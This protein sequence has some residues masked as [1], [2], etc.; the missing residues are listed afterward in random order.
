MDSSEAALELARANAQHNGM[1]DVCQFVR[2]DVAEF[3]REAAPQAW[4]IVVLDPPKLAP[5]RKVPHCKHSHCRAGK[6]RQSDSTLD[7][8]LYHVKAVNSL[9]PTGHLARLGYLAYSL[10]EGPSVGLLH[11]CCM[12]PLISLNAVAGTTIPYP[13]WLQTPDVRIST[14]AAARI[15]KV[16]DLECA[17]AAAGGARR[18]ADDMLLLGCRDAGRPAAGPG[19]G[20]ASCGFNPV[21]DLE[22][23]VKLV[24]YLLPCVQPAHGCPLTHVHAARGTTS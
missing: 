2:A 13:G 11:D 21:M 3:M 17:R 14:G 4:D 22:K 15:G 20:A 23:C 8:T 6:I 5:S 24:A 18:P 16:P 10:L 19:A 12:T 9:V 1:A 7:E